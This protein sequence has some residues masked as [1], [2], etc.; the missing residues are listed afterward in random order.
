MADKSAFTAEEWRL[1]LASPILAG[2]AVTLADP[3]GIFGTLK[4]GFA[5]ANAL[6]TA[7]KDAGA[8]AIAKAIAADFE[9]PEG[10]ALARDGM[11]ADLKGKSPA[12]MKAQA[13]DGLRQVNAILAAKAPDAAPGFRTWLKDIA[14]NAAEASSEGGFLGFGGVKVSDAEKATLAELDSALS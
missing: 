9:T 7:K 14:A 2:M 12:E 8:N 11:K 10:R 3:S 6:L 4:E 5:G 13:L 1:I